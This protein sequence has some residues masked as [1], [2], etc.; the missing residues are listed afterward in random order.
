MTPP[1]KRANRAPTAAV[2]LLLPKRSRPACDALAIGSATLT[3]PTE[4]I[5]RNVR[6]VAV[7]ATLSPSLTLIT[8]SS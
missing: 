3:V 1:L 8:V 2:S 5:S 4:L 7:T 6:P